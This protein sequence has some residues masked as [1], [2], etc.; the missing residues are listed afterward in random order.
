MAD[1]RIMA[2]GGRMTG[3]SQDVQTLFARAVQ[4]YQAGR[5]TECEQIGRQI[6]ARQ[7]RHADVLHLLGL[8]AYRQRRM[9][10]ALALLE[11]ALE[12]QPYAP[13]V[14]GPYGQALCEAGHFVQAA[15]IADRLVDL[16]PADGN[17][18]MLQGI[19]LAGCG[20]ADDAIVSFSDVIRLKP[21]SSEAFFRRGCVLKAQGRLEDAV[22]DFD[23]AVTINPK[24]FEAHLNK[25]NALFDSNLFQDAIACFDEVIRLRPDYA[26]AHNSKGNALLALKQPRDAIRSYDRAIAIRPDFA[27]AFNNRANAL[28]DM[29]LSTE[30]LAD[31][32]RAIALKPDYVSA[33]CNRGNV[34]QRLGA[35]EYAVRC[36]DQAI[37]V[38][39]SYADAYANRAV[40]LS[41][42]GRNDDAVEDY[43]RL[44]RLL[45]DRPE[46]YYDMAVT[47]L[48]MGRFD[49]GWPLFE[50]RKKLPKS[51]GFRACGQSL[52]FG[53]EDIAGRT[54]LVD[55][56]QGLGDTIQFCRFIANLRRTE[57]KIVFSVPDV[58]VRLLQNSGLQAD[59]IG[60]SSEPPHFDRHISL[61][62]LPLALK[63]AQVE[64]CGPY[65]F[66]EPD[67]VAKW[68]D[69]VAGPEFKIGISWQGNKHSPA[70]VGRSFEVRH[71]AAI[72]GIAN[73]RLISLQKNDGAEQL[74]DLPEELRVENLQQDID[75]GGDAF[76]DTAAIM[77]NLDLVIT[78]DTA[79]AHLAGALGRPVWLA[80]KSWP[81]W[82]WFIDRG[83]SPWY[84]TMTIF[85]QKSPGDWSGVF[86]DIRARLLSVL[87]Q[88][89]P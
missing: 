8:T 6:L 69:K 32:D 45:P 48:R 68:R 18:R 20:R 66:A 59:I 7:P 55:A 40:A 51:A 47:L 76:I 15:A 37:G 81:D 52:W 22:R 77:E 83:D 11:A 50:W 25:G 41:N 82:R 13:A 21:D 5:L 33:I 44:N 31:Y 30:A 36:Y 26:L 79:V 49:E 60:A 78:S 71:F 16:L 2:V 64:P 3:G 27:E 67:L 34:L 9:D 73:L 19:A 39:A 87:A 84:P 43:R 17:A 4:H 12:L 88:A 70:D 65:L 85:R 38:D 58:L 75:S 1:G 61:L 62:S 14:L 53:G 63:M 29:D 35:F 54:L 24:F 74:R 86:E 23:R 46:P 10:E 56:E 42:L 28:K 80:V 57:A 72:S 89:R